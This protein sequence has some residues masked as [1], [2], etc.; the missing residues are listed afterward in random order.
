MTGSS[1][2][3]GTARTPAGLD[4]WATLLEYEASTVLEPLLDAGE[5]LDAEDLAGKRQFPGLMAPLAGR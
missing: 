5:S 1:A 3:P 4:G 2:D